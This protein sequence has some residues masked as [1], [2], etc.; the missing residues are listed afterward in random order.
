MSPRVSAEQLRLLYRP[1]V[2][3]VVNVIIA[4]IIGMIVWPRLPQPSVALWAAAMMTV[5]VGRLMLRRAFWSLA[6]DPPSPRW[7]WAYAVGTGLT[8]ALWGT[9]AVAVPWLDAPVYHMLIGLTAAGMCAGA[10]ASLAVHMPAFCAFLLPCLLPIAGVFLAAPDAPHRGLGAMVLVFAG[11]LAL[12]AR[13]SNAALAETLRLRFHNADLVR[14]LSM[15]RDM[16]EQA[17]RSNWE[18]LAHVSHELRTPLNAIGGFADLM[19]QHMFGPLGHAKYDEYAGDIR[20]SATHL[21]DLVEEILLYSRGHTGALRLEEETVKAAAE[22][23]ACVQMVRRAAHDAGVGLSVVVAPSLP[24]LRADPVKLRQIVLNLLSNALKFT[25]AGGKVTVT[26]QADAEG[27]VTVSVADTG[28]GIDRADLPRVIEPYVQLGNA[29]VGK[30]QSGL[31]LG[32]PIVKRLVEL[33]GG[34]LVLVSEPGRGTTA[35]VCFP[36]SRSFRPG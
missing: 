36:A 8:G 3:L 16:A 27:A 5:I 9:M 29:F 19:C 2:P 11:A 25:P 13:G 24:L 12:I 4:A 17:S 34:R 28:I 21:T 35:T 23:E 20:D 33:H 6:G 1:V 26:A 15:T 10:V 32:L 14:E 22:I 18:T 30:P 31:G 7:A